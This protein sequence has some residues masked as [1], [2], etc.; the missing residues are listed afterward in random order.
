M[1]AATRPRALMPNARR[2]MRGRRRTRRGLGV[3]SK[4]RWRRSVSSVADSGGDFRDSMRYLTAPWGSRAD[5]LRPFEAA[6]VRAG[7]CEACVGVPRES[8][9]ERGS[10]CLD[11][12]LFGA[13][14]SR[15]GWS[16]RQVRQVDDVGVGC[17][18]PE[19]CVE[20]DQEGIVVGSDDDVAGMDV[21]VR[22][23]P[24]RS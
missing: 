4:Y 2:R 19:D 22:E 15:M 9:K 11:V 16:G 13:A 6:S 12:A 5:G 24:V 10:E 7:R 20:V 14:K 18:A 21:A 8:A 17:V 3:L 1:N 23:T